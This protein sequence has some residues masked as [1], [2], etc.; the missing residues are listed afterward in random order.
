MNPSRTI[1]SLTRRRASPAWASASWKI[2]VSSGTTVPTTR[3]DQSPAE[4][5]KL[6]PIFIIRS[7]S[8]CWVSVTGP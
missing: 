2:P 6:K 3:M 5:S 8:S 4:G 1:S 7:S